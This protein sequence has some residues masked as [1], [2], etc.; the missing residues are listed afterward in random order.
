MFSFYVFQDNFRILPSNDNKTW[1][2]NSLRGRSIFQNIETESLPEIG[3]IYQI[4]DTIGF[5]N[6]TKT[7]NVI[8]YNRVPKVGSSTMKSIIKTQSSVTD[9]F[10]YIERC[11]WDRTNSI[12]K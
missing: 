1:T 8:V 6:R 12:S 7:S 3:D 5:K 10:K 4:N 2:L 9:K 11:C